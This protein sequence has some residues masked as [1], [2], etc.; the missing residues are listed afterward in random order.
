MKL[1]AFTLL[2]NLAHDPGEEVTWNNGASPENPV[3][4]AP[5]GQTVKG[6]ESEIRKAIAKA[7]RM[8][9]ALN[10]DQ[11]KVTDQKFITLV[12]KILVKYLGG[13][14]EDARVFGGVSLDHWKHAAKKGQR[15]FEPEQKRQILKDLTDEMKQRIHIL[16]EQPRRK[17]NLSAYFEDTTFDQ[18]LSFESASLAAHFSTAQYFRS[19]ARERII[20]GGPIEN[21]TPG[22]GSAPMIPMPLED[23]KEELKEMID[24]LDDLIHQL[25][26]NALSKDIDDYDFDF[27]GEM[28][29]LLPVIADLLNIHLADL[30]RACNIDATLVLSADEKNADEDGITDWTFLDD[31]DMMAMLYDIRT[32]LEQVLQQTE[33][34]PRTVFDTDIYTYLHGNPYLRYEPE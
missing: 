4:I 12:E 21:R 14:S 34:N 10:S 7:D 24:N 13:L 2:N 28:E 22:Y 23:Y 33:G 30:V 8:R 15:I 20:K 16:R 11:V 32:E 25:D 31:H 26:S 9:K 5:G 17:T 29:M 1:H 19:Q 18:P 3:F 6:F 27:N